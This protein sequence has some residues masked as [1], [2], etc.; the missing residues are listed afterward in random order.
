V[1]GFMMKAGRLC[2]GGGKVKMQSRNPSLVRFRQRTDAKLRLFCFPY[3]GGPAAIFRE[4]SE[5]LNPCIEVWSVEYPGH[6]MRR[7]ETPIKQLSQLV[8]SLLPE[9]REQLVSPFAFFGHSMG[10]IVAFETLKRLTRESGPEPACF[11]V[12]ACYPPWKP[13]RRAPIHD[14]PEPEFIEQLR[15][16]GGTP[17][18]LLANRELAQLLLPALR[19]D[20]EVAQS[21]SHSMDKLHCPIFVYGGLDD[22]EARREHLSDWN[23]VCETSSVRMFP[24]GHF[25]LHS[26][27]ENLMQVLARDFLTR[28]TGISS[29]E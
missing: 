17:E 2:S 25:F 10:A 4:W 28:V 29:A 27:A 11:F 24:G 3:A 8:D 18:E 23:S 7:F 1:F 13:K 16:M 20:F 6:G 5:K 12:S 15:L 14:L 9:L 19:A 26:A 22:P 21:Y